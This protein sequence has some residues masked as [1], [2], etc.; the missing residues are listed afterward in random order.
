MV[1]FVTEYQQSFAGLFFTIGVESLSA[2]AMAILQKGFDFE[3]VFRMTKAV[4]EKGGFVEWSIMDNLPFLTMDMADEY[5]TNCA[6][7]AELARSCPHLAIFNNGQVVWPNVAIAEQYGPFTT[8]P[9]G[10]RN[11]RD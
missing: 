2:A 10:T 11:K 3:A 9:D 1:R 7:A 8:F 5:E 4:L 6:R